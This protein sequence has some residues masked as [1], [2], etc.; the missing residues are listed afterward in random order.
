M[1][2]ARSLAIACASCLL[3][4]AVSAP[5]PAQS[6]AA[7]AATAP[8]SDWAQ[9]RPYVVLVLL[10]GF[11]PDYRDAARNLLLLGKHGTWAPE[12]MLPGL[13]AFSR[14]GQFSIVTGLYPGNNGI[15]ADTFMDPAR[16]ARFSADDPKAAADG[17]WYTGIPLWSLAERH[18]MRTA[19]IQ[20]PGCA[21]QIAGFRSAYLGKDEQEPAEE[22]REIVAWLHLPAAERPHLIAAQF[23]EPGQSALKFGPDAPETRTAVRRID[24]QIGKLRADLDALHLPIDL[25]VVSDHGFVKPDGGW[26]TLAELADLTGFDTAGTLLYGKTEADRERVYNQ[27][28]KAT[29]EFFVYRLKNVPADLHNRNPRMGDP[30]IVATGPFAIR[31]QAPA[32]TADQAPR[33]VDGFDA[34]LVPQMKAIFFAAGPDILEGRTVASFENVNL[35]PWLAHLLG[36]IS[37]KTDGSL[38]VLSGTLRDNGDETV[39]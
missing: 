13:P 22:V 9:S 31:A 24:V 30:V 2:M 36:L 6:D 20:W 3:A 14:P 33:A 19:C 10:Q 27:L 4:A 17:S 5:L 23:A 39:K 28:K 32:G 1:R 25:V 18:G 37:P 8:N 35:Y 15:V 26:I 16:Q 11:R 34:R 12:G 29:S 7:P 21:A 38:N